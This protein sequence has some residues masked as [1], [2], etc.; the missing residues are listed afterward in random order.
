MNFTD[1]YWMQLALD[2]AQQAAAAGEVPVGA[3]VVRDNQLIGAGFNQP[4][5]LCDPTAH[6]EIVALRDASKKVS[7]YRLPDTTL[8]VTIEPCAMCAGALV[9]ARIKRLVFGAPEPRAGAVVS[10]LQLLDGAHLN[11][12]IEVQS[13][14][15][16][17]Q[18]TEAMRTFFRSRRGGGEK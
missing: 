8:Y 10:N 7:N 11:H 5:S 17:E 3:I 18:S 15:L 9:H 13:G 12:R 1:E 4:I 16:A 6:A 2:Q 14:V